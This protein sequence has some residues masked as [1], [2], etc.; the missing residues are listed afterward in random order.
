MPASLGR[1]PHATVR[2][3]SIAP[4]VVLIY[5]T[6]G[7]VKAQQKHKARGKLFVR[8]RIDTLLDAGSPFLEIGALAGHKLYSDEVPSGG[9]V[10]GIGRI[11]GCVRCCFLGSPSPLFK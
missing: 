7:G 4:D 5:A 9:I 8:E 1:I 6:G 10:T 11:E 2:M 3:R